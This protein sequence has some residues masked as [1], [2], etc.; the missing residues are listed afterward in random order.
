MICQTFPPYGKWCHNVNT[1]QYIIPLQ[2]LVEQFLQK[3]STTKALRKDVIIGRE[4]KVEIVKRDDCGGIPVDIN[5]S[6]DHYY[7]LLYP[8][9]GELT[10]L[11]FNVTEYLGYLQTKRLGHTVIY[12]P[13]ISSTQ[14]LFTGYSC[15]GLFIA[16]SL[17]VVYYL[18]IFHFQS[19]SLLS[20]VSLQLPVSKYEEK[21]C[22]FFHILTNYLLLGRTG[23]S[24]ISPQGCLMFT[25][26]LKLKSDTRLAGHITILQHL[27]ALSF[28]NGVRSLPGYQV[29]HNYVHCDY[30]YQTCVGVRGTNKMAE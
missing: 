27:T 26:L 30:S 20:Q 29:R 16:T 24:W 19:L 6:H 3:A 11:P 28:V 1:L 21:V 9:K 5:P 23:N 18:E 15:T 8:N 12:S 22:Q 2:K 13:V 4:N 10:G 17:L 7:L 25:L 14:T